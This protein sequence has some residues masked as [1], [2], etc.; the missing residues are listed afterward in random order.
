MRRKTLVKKAGTLI[1]VEVSKINPLDLS[2]IYEDGYKRGFKMGK[3]AGIKYAKE[4]WF[5][6]H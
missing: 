4:N 1:E 5:R 3:K 2:V 6:S